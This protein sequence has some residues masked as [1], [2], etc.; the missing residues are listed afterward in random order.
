MFKLTLPFTATIVGVLIAGHAL[1]DDG[2]PFDEIVVSAA[3]VPLAVSDIGNA[4]TIIDSG[5][6]ARR[7][8]QNVADLLRSVPGFSVSRTGVTGSQTQVRVRGSEANQ[9]LVLIDG[10]RVN[11]PGTADEFRWEYLSTTQI[12]RVEIVRGAQST[13]WGTDAIG[14]VVNII[15]R[16]QSRDQQV[17]GYAEAGSLGTTNAGVDLRAGS[18]DWSLSAGVDRQDTDGDNISRLGDEDDGAT[19]TTASVSADYDAG[20]GF[21]IESG[22]RYTDAE[23]AFDGV[24][25]STGLPADSDSIGETETL[26]AHLRGTWQAA[27]SD[28]T[29]RGTLRW[30]DG[31]N[32]TVVDGTSSGSTASDRLTLGY[33][34]DVVLGDGGLTLAAE[35]EST[36]FSQR[37]PNVFGDPNQDQSMDVSSFIAEYRGSVSDRLSWIVSGRF[38]SNSDFDDAF[39]GRISG[40]YAASDN[41]RLRASVGT[42]QKNPTFTERFGFFPGS[43][44]G[45][46]DLKPERSLSI[47][48]GIDG[49]ALNEALEWQVTIFSQDLEDEI[50]GFVFTENFEVTAENQQGESKRRGAELGAQWRLND[51]FGVDATYTYVDATEPDGA[52][53]DIDE[54]R[55]PRHTAAVGVDLDAMQGRWTNRLTAEYGGT[56]NDRF[57]PPFPQPSQIVT[58]GNFWLLELSSRFAVND[59]LTVYVRGTNLLDEDYEEVFGYQTL[60]RAAFIGA[61]FNF[62]L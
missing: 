32:D 1:A 35:H 23:S 39:N 48:V 61:R 9:V 55:R 53:N 46:P 22:L 21:T 25:F 41:M 10:N 29:H 3:R 52:G 57:F 37:G 2:R 33:Q 44:I 24:D 62:A 11:D 60:G 38:D 56:R 27:N 51:R 31:S 59:N 58:I 5:D 8:A 19:L 42:G 49:F 30:F 12:E 20:R 17:G 18:G 36:D 4:V 34:F 15:T 54:L 6:I 47:D 45:N 14:G 16:S 43:F 40:S 28:I 50:N 26:T 7:Q 13:L